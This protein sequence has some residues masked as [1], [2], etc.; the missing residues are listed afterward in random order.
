[1][2]LDGTNNSVGMEYELEQRGSIKS[3]CE[4]DRLRLLL[5]DL[6]SLNRYFRWRRHFWNLMI[7]E[8]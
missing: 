7:R 2:F 6:A 3:K 1:M 5:K 8:L 4:R